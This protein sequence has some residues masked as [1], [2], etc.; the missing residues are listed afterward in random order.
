[1]NVN[2]LTNLTRLLLLKCRNDMQVVVSAK[3]QLFR[4]KLGW[5]LAD[6]I[7]IDFITWRAI[8]T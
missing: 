7:V 6:D 4:F 5:S 3:L 8:V 2:K 1:M